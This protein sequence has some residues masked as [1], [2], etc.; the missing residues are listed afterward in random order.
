M[1][2]FLLDVNVLIALWWPAH[3]QHRSVQSWFARH[4]TKGWA[5][6]AATQAGFVRILSNPL[7]T[8]DAVRPEDAMALMEANTTQP[9]H[10]F[11][12]D[13]IDF[14]HAVA[15][16]RSRITGH[17]QITD[18]FLL[19]LALHHQGK[20]A[21]MDVGIQALLK[22]QHQIRQAIELIA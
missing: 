6:C 15:P 7:L 20:L 19:G 21:T 10:T 12:G 2:G 11:W 4:S 14:L 5:T 17:R 13:G 22:D 3:K 16:L 1:T 18:A 9:D 8:R